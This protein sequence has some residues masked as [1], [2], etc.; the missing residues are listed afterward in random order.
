MR[1]IIC[2][3]A[4]IEK[5]LD[6]GAHPVSTFFLPDADAKEKNINLSLAQCADCGTVQLVEPVPYQDLVPPEFVSAREPEDHLDEAVEKMCALPGLGTDSIVAAVSYKDDTTVDRFIARGFGKTWRIDLAEDLGITDPNANIE[7]LQACISPATMA[8]IA[9]RR[10]A[11]DQLIVRH[12]SEHAEDPGAYMAG[13]A[14]LVRPGGYIMIEIPD[15]TRNLELNDYCMI[16]EEH[17]LYLTPATLR[18]FAS[19]GGFDM[20]TLDVYPRSFENSIVYV[21]RKTTGPRAPVVAPEAKAEVGILARYA[22]AYEPAKRELRDRLQ[23]IRDTKGPVV[24]FGAGH[25]ACAFVN[26]MDVADLIDFVADDTPVKQGKFL[27]GAKLPIVSSA[28]LVERGAALC[29]LA[30]TI[31]NEDKVISKNT[32]FMDAGGVFQSIFRA[33]GRSVF[34]G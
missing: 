24:L 12:I 4:N 30:L 1:C 20:V 23:A 10:G 15:C 7:S 21:G 17:S 11:A 33:S 18:G 29:L 9:A 2:K 34:Q 22:A 3:S 26:Y 25:L 31:E 8:P 16:W 28:A 32:A 19:M 27:P 5:Q 6:V 14:E 13:L